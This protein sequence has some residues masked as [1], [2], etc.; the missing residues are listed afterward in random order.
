MERIFFE[1]LFFLKTILPFNSF[2][3]LLLMNLL[4]QSSRLEMHAQ[5]VVVVDDQW[6]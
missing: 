1:F 6:W 4:H 5:V 3:L 2:S